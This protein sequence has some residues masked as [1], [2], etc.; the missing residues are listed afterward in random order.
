[1]TAVKDEAAKL[2]ASLPD[3]ATWDDLMDEIYVRQAI[4]AGL[5]DSDADDVTSIEEVRGD[6]RRLSG[7][8][9]RPGQ[10]PVSVEEMN[11]SIREYHARKR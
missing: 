7:M 6:Y 10:R 5:A 3:D 8:L 11:E 9:E 4:E 2:V 1:M